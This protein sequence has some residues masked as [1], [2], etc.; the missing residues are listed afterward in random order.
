MIV[1][2]REFKEVW[3]V[4]F[5]F[6][7]APGNIPKPICLVALELSSGRKLRIWEDGLRGR[8]SAPYPTNAESLVVAYYAS[9]EIG[10]HLALGWDLP[11]C[12]LDLYVE[13]RNLTNGKSVPCGSGL[14][15]ALSYFGLDSINSAEK[16][17]MRELAMRGSPWTNQEKD[18]LLDYCE[19]DVQALA[20]LLP[21]MNKDLDTQ[22]ALLRGR[23]MKAA[24][25]IEHNGIPIDT[26]SPKFYREALP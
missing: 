13:F 22:R 15:G 23:Y 20:K 25:R 10:C 16:E 1:G 17:S 26:E 21:C 14:L 8:T 7:A 24:A 11:E 2:N 18:A 3:A 19:S 6:S 12:V 9:A 5:E 4:D